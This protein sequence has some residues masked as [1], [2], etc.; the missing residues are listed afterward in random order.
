MDVRSVLL[1]GPGVRPF[2]NIAD[3]LAVRASTYAQAEALPMFARRMDT[4]LGIGIAL[5]DEL[6]K[7]HGTLDAIRGPLQRLRAAFAA[8]AAS[9]LDPSDMQRIAPALADEARE[10]ALTGQR[11]LTTHLKSQPLV[12][13][14][15]GA[16][17]V[18][19]L[20]RTALK[21]EIGVLAEV[22]DDGAVSIVGQGSAAIFRGS[23][24]SRIRNADLLRNAGR[25]EAGG[26]GYYF[27][28]VAR[29]AR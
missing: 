20:T 11:L 2:A 21:E 17:G 19:V 1:L 29:F 7:T 8:G 26:V 12:V 9:S 5:L 25:V 24:I 16:D 3:D 18:R 27:S 13:A 14:I 28:D 4:E 10:A 6:A 22:A 15:D 23:S